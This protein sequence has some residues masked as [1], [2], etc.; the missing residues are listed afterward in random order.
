M[1]T[2]AV[3]DECE[4]E[5][6][7]SGHAVAPQSVYDITPITSHHHRLSTFA[8]IAHVLRHFWMLEELNEGTRDVPAVRLRRRS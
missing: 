7:E 6:F 3:A 5:F 1:K 4:A 8:T 2:I